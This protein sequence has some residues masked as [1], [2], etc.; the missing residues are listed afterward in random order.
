MPGESAAALAASPLPLHTHDVFQAGIMSSRLAQFIWKSKENAG[1][2]TK[3]FS[4]IHEYILATSK[5]DVLSLMAPPGDE[6]IAPCK[7]Q[8]SK[9]AANDQR[10]ED[11][12]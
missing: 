11:L 4:G 1:V 9:Y 5:G 2:L 7:G 3:G 6:E 10:A 8:D 12:A